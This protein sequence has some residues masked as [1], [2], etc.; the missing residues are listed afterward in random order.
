MHCVCPQC[1]SQQLLRNKRQAH[2]SNDLPAV[3][4]STEVSTKQQGVFFHEYDVRASNNV[5][6][7]SLI[8]VLGRLSSGPSPFS[9]Y[10]ELKNVYEEYAYTFESVKNIRNK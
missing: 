7:Y 8:I 10:L 9:K 1:I 6:W 4:V 2:A 5:T 3:S